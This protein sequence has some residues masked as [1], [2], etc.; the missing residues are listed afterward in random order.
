MVKAGLPLSQLDRVFLTHHHFDHIGDLYDVAL[1]S[2]LAGRRTPLRI[3]GPPETKRIVDALLTQIY[4]KDI[5]WRDQGEPTLGGWPPVYTRD[6]AT[7]IVEQTENWTI[8][9][10]NVVHGHGLDLSPAFVKRWICYGYRFEAE[11]KVIA[12]SGDTVECAGLQRLARDADVLVQCCYLAE[13]EMESEH[14]KRLA[15][16]SIACSNTVGKIA[17]QAGVKTLVLTHHRPRKAD[18]SDILARLE[19]EVR[20]DFKGH[21][22]IARDLDEIELA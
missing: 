17:A 22:V 21:L 12:V 9:A 1:C 18:D 11:G 3:Y 16:Y 20:R 15:R 8:T 19:D 4:D 2:W 10:E 5:E 7:G 13:E 6:I 14:W